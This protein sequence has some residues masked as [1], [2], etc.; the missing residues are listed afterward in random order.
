MILV[1]L[2]RLDAVINNYLL[3]IALS[4]LSLFDL[5]VYFE[6]LKIENLLNVFYLHLIV[7]V[8]ILL[9]EGLIFGKILYAHRTRERKWRK[10]INDAKNPNSIIRLNALTKICELLSL[11]VHTITRFFIHN[12]TVTVFLL[13]L[14]TADVAIQCKAL[15]GLQSIAIC[16][17]RYA[18]HIVDAGG[19]AKLIKMLQSN[20]SQVCEYTLSLLNILTKCEFK[21]CDECIS[22]NIFSK[23]MKFATP[24]AWLEHARITAKFVSD[25]CKYSNSP[26]ND[27]TMVQLT[28]LIEKLRE[29]SNKEVKDEVL[30][31]L[32]Y[33][34]KNG[35]DPAKIVPKRVN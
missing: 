5:F 1:K 10:L 2:D 17:K 9:L 8:I 35:N 13:S 33:M 23:L 19:A 7:A 4:F 16:T 24:E 31:A 27:K 6:L 26:F 30:S 25:F 12:G 28:P 34:A 22:N 21:F 32:S 11:N 15:I 18:Q 3:P 20:S 29:Y 14:N